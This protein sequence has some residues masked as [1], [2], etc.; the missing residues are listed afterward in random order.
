MIMNS[1]KEG[2]GRKWVWPFEIVLLE[3]ILR[4]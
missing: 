1:K 3:F 2:F 4:D